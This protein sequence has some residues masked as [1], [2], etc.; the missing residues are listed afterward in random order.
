MLIQASCERLP[1]P[2][3]SVDLIFTDPPYLRRFLPCYEWLAKEAARVL[4][5]GGFV[6]TMCGGAYLNH[7]FRAFDGA[8]LTYY[9]KYEVGL[10]GQAGGIAWVNVGGNI[11]KPVAVRSKS[12]LAYSNGPAVSRTGTISYI[13]SDGADKRYHAWGQ[14]VSSARYFVDCFSKE[15]DLVLDPF[16]GGGTSAVACELLNRRWI[17]SDIDPVALMTSAK[18]MA[19]AQLPHAVSM[20]AGAG[21]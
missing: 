14:D 7:I 6:L 21:W 1:L 8:G 20:F 19:G 17:G 10:A 2:A 9:W 12:V 18:R 16:I 15:G 4:R 5:P 11:R 3:A 13:R